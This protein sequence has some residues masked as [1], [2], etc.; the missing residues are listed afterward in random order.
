MDGIGGVLSMKNALLRVENKDSMARLRK[1]F[2]SLLES[3]FIDVLLVPKELPAGDGF[4]QSLIKDPDMLE[5]SNPVAPTIAVQSA[6]I[7][8]ELTSGNNDERIG[9]VLKPCEL[10]ASIELVKFLQV[11]LDNVVTI[12]VDCA[13]TYK[14]SDYAGM[15]QKEGEPEPAAFFDGFR[16]TETKDAGCPVYREACRICEDPVPLNA[17]ITLG[18]FGYEPSEEIFVSAG[19]KIEKEFFEKLALDINEG[20]SE[21]RDQVIREVF[22]RRRNERHRVIEQL[23]GQIGSMEN[24]M[25]MMSTCIRCHNCMNVCPICY[26]KE[27]VFESPVFDRKSWQFSSLASRKGAVR[28][29]GDTLIFHLTRMSHMAT[30]C[31]G[32]GMCDSACPSE[33]PVS[34]IFGLIGRGLQE[35]FDYVP[36]KDAAHKPPVTVF[37]EDEFADKRGIE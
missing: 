27:C 23:Q 32:C 14:V 18:F 11:N 28:M 7:L 25:N 20:S 26:C 15:V 9:A 4:V 8:S 12:G 17:D 3:K 21:S 6:R 13:G 31:I 5:G 22:T 36:G 33:L 37:K 16:D 19:D 34:S 1:F 35:M 29:P 24:L 2:R 10:K 30:S